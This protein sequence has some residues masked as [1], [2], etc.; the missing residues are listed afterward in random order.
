MHTQWL[1]VKAIKEAAIS[2]AAAGIAD[3]KMDLGQY[4]TEHGGAFLTYGSAA[5][6]EM[7]FDCNVRIAVK[8][9]PSN[10]G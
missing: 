1:T 3:L 9:D 10:L 4:A 7:R 5:R 6:G 8:G 2:E